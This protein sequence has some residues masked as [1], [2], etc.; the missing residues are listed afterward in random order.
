MVQAVP[1]SLY[2]MSVARTW[3]RRPFLSEVLSE[4]RSPKVATSRIPASPRMTAA[5]ST[6]NREGVPT[7]SHVVPT[8]VEG[9]VVGGGEAVDVSPDDAAALQ[10]GQEHVPGSCGGDDDVG[11]AV[12]GPVRGH[13]GPR[14]GLGT[15]R[16]RDGHVR[17]PEEHDLG[18]VVED[19]LQQHLVELG[20]V[21]ISPYRHL[22]VRDGPVQGGSL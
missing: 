7:D 4:G 10:E 14:E 9:P 5:M 1:L 8:H 13:Y 19:G 22:R 17:V 3:H 2:T 21:Y 20:R 12:Q 18:E 6:P 11:Q 16:W 15:V